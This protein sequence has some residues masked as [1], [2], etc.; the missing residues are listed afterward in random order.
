MA[1]KARKDAKLRSSG[2]S[3]KRKSTRKRGSGSLAGATAAKKHSSKKAATTAAKGGSS[4]VAAAAKKRAK[5]KPAAPKRAGSGKKAKA[6]RK[7]PGPPC[8]ESPNVIARSENEVAGYLGVTGR[9]VRNWKQAGMPYSP[10]RY[11]L[12]A[13]QRWRQVRDGAPPKSEDA[14]YWDIQWRKARAQNEQLRYEEAVG[15]L[16]PVEEARRT[17][18]AHILACRR[19]LM[20]LARA[21]APRLEGQTAFEIRGM[22]EEKLRDAI[23]SLGDAE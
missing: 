11:D 2:P 23:V 6:V 13:I 8:E 21:L 22:L 10:R 3:N 17:W 16:I 4:K 15:N 18:T 1:A 14:K 19:R 9:T 5:T 12:Q 7:T 20:G